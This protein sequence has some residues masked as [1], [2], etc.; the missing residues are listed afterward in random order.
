[1]IMKQKNKFGYM[2]FK[3]YVRFLL[4]RLLYRKH[5]FIGKD[6]LPADG[7]PFIVPANHQN[8]AIDPVAMVLAYPQKVHPYVLA[9]GGVFRWSPI[10]NAIWDWVGMLPA[11]RMDYEGVEDALNR[12]KYVVDFAATKMMEGHPVMLFP[13]M[14]HHDEHWM[15]TWTPG[16]LEIAFQAA[17]KLHFE[18]DVKVV[19]MAHHYSSY[20]GAQGS[21]LLQYDKP[22]SLMP[23]YEQYKAKPRTTIRQINAILRERV[24]AM[25][26]Y[27]DDMEHHDLYDFVRKTRFGDD[28]AR[29]LGLRP[30]YLPDRLS[31]DKQLWA[32]IEDGVQTKPDGHTIVDKMTDTWQTIRR[33]EKH[34]HLREHAS[35]AKRLSWP[36]IAASLL[37]QLAL[38]PLWIVS[39]FPAA[40]W[41]YVPPM[42]MPGKEDRYY[43]LY[44]QAMQLIVDVLVLVPLT[45][46]VTVLVLGLVWGWWWQAVVWIV[47]WYPLSLFA[48]YNGNRMRRTFEQVVLRTRKSDAA[49][50]DA[51]YT[52]LYGLLAQLTTKTQG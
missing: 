50:L 31:A 18:K 48:W 45:I 23:Y 3:H 44:T 41:Y 33:E 13:E 17:E 30:D 4:D 25:M 7:E 11:F 6:N 38:L 1:M 22:F 34:L 21:Y 12:T 40:L 2:L 5:Y 42:F 51:L 52:T 24:K 15:R 43:K 46:L 47:L 32:D 28:Y 29:H 39:L 26:L 37:V 9:M 36:C 8:T 10:I 49:R 14:D 35:E 19:P 20:Y 16:Y 27:T